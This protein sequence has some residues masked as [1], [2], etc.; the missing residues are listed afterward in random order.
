MAHIM[1]NSHHAEARLDRSSDTDAALMD[2]LNGLNDT[3]AD[4]AYGFASCADYSNIGQHRTL[5]RLRAQQCDEAREQLHE[6]VLRL[7]GVPARGGSASGA[8]HRGWVA[9]RGTLSGLRDQSIV[10]EC[11]R[12]ETV[13]RDRYQEALR[14][15]L[16]TEARQLLERHLRGVNANLKQIKM[17]RDA[18]PRVTV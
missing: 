7:G 14:H 13:A 8:L 11:E 17:L 2:L 18:T 12:G 9:V 15:D 16:P 6:L 1:S 5:F 3:C 10:A 4:G